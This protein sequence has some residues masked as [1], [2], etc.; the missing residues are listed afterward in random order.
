MHWV[1]STGTVPYLTLASQGCAPAD[2]TERMP[3]KAVFWF[4]AGFAAEE[5]VAAPVTCLTLSY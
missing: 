1:T 2:F 3:L 4:R 5:A